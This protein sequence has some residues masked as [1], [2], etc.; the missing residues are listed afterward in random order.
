MIK[1]ERLGHVVL[2]VRDLQRSRKF[3]TEVL[4]MDVMMEVAAIGGVF[5]ANNRRDHHEIAL[6]ELGQEA[7]GLRVKQIGL[8]HIAFRLRN[9]EE[10]RAAYEELK[11]KGVPISFTVD[12][13]VTKSVYFRDPDGH[14]LEVYCDNPPE[15]IAK[16]ANPYLGM[17]KLDFA[18][19]DPGLAEAMAQLGVGNP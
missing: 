8:S 15:V 5:L 3:Y 19:N 18:P 14:E 4:G 13:G 6:F 2:K 12:H 17:S 7:E 9:E 11:E 1:A 16:L 10:L